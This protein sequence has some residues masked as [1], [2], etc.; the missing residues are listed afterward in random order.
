MFRGPSVIFAVLVAAM[1][2]GL[3]FRKK[4]DGPLTASGAR[5]TLAGTPG[6]LF[7]PLFTRPIVTPGTGPGEMFET[8]GDRFD[9]LRPAER[10]LEAAEADDALI[11]IAINGADLSPAVPT[12]PVV[13]V[14]TV[15]RLQ[16]TR[17]TLVTVSR[18]VSRIR[19]NVAAGRDPRAGEPG[20]RGVT[21]A[22]RPLPAST[23]G[24]DPLFA[25]EFG[26]F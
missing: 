13:S 12:R 25:E 8:G 14:P 18:E 3:T 1:L 4:D 24:L 15:T 16:P 9:R 7:G 5:E 2:F 11:D 26:Q 20:L 22:T 23:I 10:A 17:Q 6:P 19:A 21:P